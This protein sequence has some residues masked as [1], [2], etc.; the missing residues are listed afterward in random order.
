MRSEIKANDLFLK[1]KKKVKNF[2]LIEKPS[3]P[4]KKKAPNYSTSEHYYNV[5]GSSSKEVGA[6]RPLT[7]KEHY[8]NIYIDVLD[9]ITNVIKD[10]FN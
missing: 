5:V 7:P 10:R 2:K 4:R 8:N 6:Y 3:L 9:T 1:T